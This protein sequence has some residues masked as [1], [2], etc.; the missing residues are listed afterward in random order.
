[1]LLDSH[2]RF[3]RLPFDNSTLVRLFKKFFGLSKT[4]AKTYRALTSEPNKSLALYG[5][6]KEQIPFLWNVAPWESLQAPRW[7]PPCMEE[8]NVSR[9]KKP[10][11]MH[12]FNSS[13]KSGH[14]AQHLWPW[15]WAFSFWLRP[16]Y[17]GLIRVST[18]YIL[19]RRTGELQSPTSE[20]VRRL[21]HVSKCNL[22]TMTKEFFTLCGPSNCGVTSPPECVAKCLPARTEGVILRNS[23]WKKCML[24]THS[25]YST[26][27]WHIFRPITHV[28]LRNLY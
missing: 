10:F 5:Q 23:S 24:S 16:L 21:Y 26:V 12:L 9:N 25:N 6:L 27:E 3:C 28:L 18:Q 1:M 11:H 17:P 14:S 4:R 19:D 13:A 8:R 2:V 20:L 22:E 15:R 7:G